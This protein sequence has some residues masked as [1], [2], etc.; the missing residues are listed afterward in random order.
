MKNPFPQVVE[1]KYL[2]EYRILVVFRDG[3]SGEVDLRSELYGEVFSPLKD[4]AYFR[5]FSVHPELHTL[6]WPNGADFAPEF[7][8]QLA[9][10]VQTQR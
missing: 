7:L 9:G 1:A 5:K 3:V 10:A 4:E 2:G 6:V 8:Y